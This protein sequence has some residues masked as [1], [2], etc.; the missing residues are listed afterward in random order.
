MW[1][2]SQLARECG[3]SIEVLRFYE[4]KG[5]IQ[6]PPRSSSGYRLYDEA[7][8]DRIRFIRNAK[9]TG[10]TLAEIAELLRL[11]AT[12]KHQCQTIMNQ[13][14]KKLAEVEDRIQALQ[15][16]RRA[17]KRLI[18]QCRKSIP[19]DECPILTSFQA[20]NKST[21]KAAR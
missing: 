3:I 12:Q 20:E 19:S 11:K 14:E 13:A 10:F 1:T 16:M 6:P 9:N 17:L 5:L 7:Y 15:S 4:K 8:R 18:A 2:R 21:R